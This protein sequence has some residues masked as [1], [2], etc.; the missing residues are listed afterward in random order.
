MKFLV[1]GT[2]FDLS[3]QSSFQKLHQA[4]G[5][6]LWELYGAGVLQEALFGKELSCVS[7]V[8]ECV[9]RNEAEQLIKMLPSAKSELIRYQISEL[10]AFPA[11]TEQFS[12]HHSK[13]PF[14]M[15]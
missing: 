7:F 10:F 15:C 5:K 12:R 1:I 6:A 8:I 4:E 11:L 2:F 14:W 9:N 3:Q 13:L